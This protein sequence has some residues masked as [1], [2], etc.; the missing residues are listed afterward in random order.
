MTASSE[1]LPKC[2]SGKGAR[3]TGLV[4][5]GG[6]VSQN[7]PDVRYPR[8]VRVDS[9]GSTD[10]V[11]RFGAAE[12]LQP[13]TSPTGQALTAWAKII[14]TRTGRA[15]TLDL[16]FNGS[17]GDEGAIVEKMRSGNQV[18]VALVST[19]GL[20][21]IWRPIQ[22]LQVPGLFDTWTQLDAARVSMQAETDT[23]FASAGMVILGPVDFGWARV[24]S[25]GTEVRSTTDL[26]GR[27]AWMWSD[28]LIAP[29][30]HRTAG[31]F[32]L[33]PLSVPAVLPALNASNVDVI[34]SSCVQAVSRSWVSKLDNVVANLSMGAEIGALVVKRAT[35]EA[36]TPEQ[37]KIVV[38]TGA[39][40]ASSLNAAR[41]WDEECLAKW[42][43]A[44]SR[45][46]II[47]PDQL[48]QWNDVFTRTRA[49]LG[50]GVIDPALLMKLEAARK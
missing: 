12:K 46:T 44:I 35:L 26:Q 10:H 24:M 25:R 48:A 14:A 50:Q 20:S 13:K 33:K 8:Y 5:A 38:D 30:F 1:V 18:D 49:A 28:D 27:S 34:F 43:K 4:A 6:E 42:S 2:D 7:R 15:V 45:T 17:D 37:R 40:V 3:G 21:K 23:N 16:H 41:R 19:V 29:V 11:P 32:T 36:L 22:A 39:A 47:T 9:Q 31:S